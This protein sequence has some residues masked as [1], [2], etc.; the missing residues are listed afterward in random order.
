M[1]VDAGSV[2]TMA[3]LSLLT[4]ACPCTAPTE[5][6]EIRKRAGDMWNTLVKHGHTLHYYCDSL[7]PSFDDN[8]WPFASTRNELSLMMYDFIEGHFKSKEINQKMDV[9]SFREVMESVP[10]IEE[11][12]RLSKVKD[13]VI[14][15]EA[16]PF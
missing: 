3:A 7:F 13:N 2:F 9:K 4:G 10:E 5:G 6:A 1:K 8:S 12:Y 15:E 11:K 16:L 14:R